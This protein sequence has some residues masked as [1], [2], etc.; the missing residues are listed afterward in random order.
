LKTCTK[1]KNTYDYASFHKELRNKDGFSSWCKKCVKI[2]SATYYTKNRELVNSKAKLYHRNNKEK[3][4]LAQRRYIENNK[5][6]TLGRQLM[7]YWPGCTAMEAYEKYMYLQNKQGNLC[8]ICFQPETTR[9]QYTG[10]IRRLSVDHCH[11]TGL[12]RGLLCG[13]HNKAIGLIDESI[14]IAYNVIKYIQGDNG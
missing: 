11:T 3:T 6:L 8:A 9:H 4:V 10:K 13:K 7:K 12:V 5:E 1:C 2:S 14:E